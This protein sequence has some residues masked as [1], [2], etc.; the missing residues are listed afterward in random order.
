MP[1][2]LHDFTVKAD[3]STVYRAITSPEGLDQWW[4]RRAQ[5]HPEAGQEYELWFGPD[6]D[7]RARV[8]E[9]LPGQCFGFEMTG[10]APDWLGTRVRFALEAEGDTTKVRFSHSGWQS[11]SEHFKTSSYC[12]AMYLRVM[13]R[14]VECG[15]QVRY[16]DRLG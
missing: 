11:E 3:P 2:I 9:A 8:I 15:E 13:R 16:E 5:G 1:D 14:F 4:T 6:A 12:W 7:W 10:A